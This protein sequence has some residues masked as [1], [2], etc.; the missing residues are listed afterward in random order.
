MKSPSTTDADRLAAFHIK[1]LCTVMVKLAN[2]DLERRLKDKDIHINLGAL[3]VLRILRRA[4]ITIQDVSARLIVMPATL[5]P[6]ID[7]LEGKGLLKRM[8]DKTDRRKSPLH[9]TPKGTNLL[10]ETSEIGK[11]RLIVEGT[12]RLGKR[13]SGKLIVLLEELTC[14]IAGDDTIC[15]T[16]KENVTSAVKSSATARA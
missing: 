15:K 6:I 5:I 14:A 8:K 3:M 10:I 11:N 13:K 12:G 7:E 16:I 9:I 1:A 4:P 2:Q